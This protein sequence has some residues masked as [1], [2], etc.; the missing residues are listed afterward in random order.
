MDGFKT[1]DWAL[2]RKQKQHLVRLVA[3]LHEEEQELVEPELVDGVI[4]LLDNLQDEAVKKDY[5]SEFVVFD[6]LESMT[7]RELCQ[8]IVE[9]IRPSTTPNPDETTDGE[10]LDMIYELAKAQ[11]MN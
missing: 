11:E 10:I 9:L 7:K 8:K 3:T 2:L 4:C 6:T 1:M 5:A